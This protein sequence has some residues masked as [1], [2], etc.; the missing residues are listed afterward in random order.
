M[1]AI[2]SLLRRERIIVI[3]ALAALTLL[4]WLY[5]WRGAGMGMTALS[6]TQLALFPHLTPEPMADMV[7]PP[8]SWFTIVAMWWVMMIAMMTPSAVE[9]GRASCRERVWTVV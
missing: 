8:L 1:S 3:A 5:L 7:M 9:I 4:A 2:E 6:M